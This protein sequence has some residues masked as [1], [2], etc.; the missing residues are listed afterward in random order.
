MSYSLRD[1]PL[2][3]K[4]VA[5]VFLMAVG[6]G[7]TSAMVQLHMQDAKSG[8]P[9]P[10]VDDVIRKY[11]G[12]RKY[13]PNAPQA[14]P[15]SRLESLV[16]AEPPAISGAS[17]SA[18]FTTEDR[19]K[20][21]LKFANATRGQLPEVVEQIKAERRGEQ[22]ALKLWINTPE[23]DRRAAYEADRFVP[24]P[25]EV[26]KHLTPAL[27]AGNVVKVKSIIE[28]R[29]VTCHSKGGDKEDVPLDTYDGLAPFMVAD[30]VAPAGDWVKVEEPIS[31]TKL[32]QSTHAHLLSF[33]VLFSLTGLIFALSS[34]PTGMR[35][36]LGPW[37][38]LAVFA[39]VSLWW[40][41]RL[42]DQWGPYF[43][44][45][46]IFTG[47]LAGA[48]L[49]AQIVLSLFNM[50]GPKGKV[51]VAGLFVA[52]GVV[53]GLMWLNVFEPGLRSKAELLKKDDKPKDEKT[54]KKDTTNGNPPKLD[55]NNNQVAP[56]VTPKAP[57]SWAEDLLTFPV[58]GP[59]GNVLTMEQTPWG[60][61][62]DGNMSRAFFDKD[63]FFKEF[64]ADPANAPADKDKLT[65][66]RDGE[67]LA[68][69]AWVRTA[70][71]ARRA[72]YDT[73]ALP[74]PAEL[75]GKPITPKYLKDGKVLV[76]TIIADRCLKC[77]GEGKK[78]YDDYPLDGY[79]KWKKY[80]EPS[81][82]APPTPPAPEPKAPPVPVPTPAPP[83]KAVDP[84]PPIKDD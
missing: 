53:A 25:G 22:L 73:D 75:A 37:V 43:A 18:A 57:P 58:K 13:D 24:P 20:G 70:D 55:G 29:C 71:A 45:G 31:T 2:P 49:F 63:K 32:T 59:D 42:S 38:V 83:A 72:A 19:A 79:D 15:V 30:A 50:Y 23:A 10:T 8:K 76:T 80:F 14:R 26:P 11:T 66:E 48:G 4:V 60:S 84:I 16:M 17:M 68:V 82:A 40:L 5:S 9:M 35:C 78:Q 41:A 36:V 1:L 33:A 62:P 34:Y 64:V 28:H 39:D 44:M 7:Y 74:L 6:A 52:G 77:H 69:I 81:G 3:V 65:A 61:G 21:A 67:R 47:M 51:V 54:V 27:V 56:K 46:I 12:K